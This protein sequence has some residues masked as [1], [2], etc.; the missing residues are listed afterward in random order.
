MR[1]DYEVDEPA[2][3]GSPSSM[4]ETAPAPEP[5]RDAAPPRHGPLTPVEVSTVGI[6]SGLA[7]VLGVLAT[8][9]PFLNAVFQMLAAVPIAMVTVRL[10]A[11][12]AVAS[13]AVTLLVTLVLGG[14][15]SALN[16]GQSALA[17]AVAGVLLRLQVGLGGATLAGLGLGAAL[18]GISVGVL[19]VLVDLRELALQTARVT[20]VGYLDLFGRWSVLTPVTDAL[21]RVVDWG[22][23]W[24]FAVLPA[25]AIL[26]TVL[27]VVLSWW[28]LGIVLARLRLG[29]V[30]DP[31]QTALDQARD[32]RSDLSLAD[33]APGPLPVTL[34]GVRFRYPGAPTGP[35]GDALRGVDLTIRDGEF[36]VVAGPNGSGKSTL[37]WILAGAEP[38]GGQVDRPGPVGLGRHGGTA[39]LAQ[40][41]EL[42]MLGDTVA[43]DIVWGLP[44]ADAADVDV[45]DLL[46]LVG[47]PG[48]GAARTSHLSG[49]QLQRLALAGA[50]ARRPRLLLSDESTAMVDPAGRR[51]L[52]A[53]LS[54]LPA[55]GTTVVHITH[56]LDEAR[57]AHRLVRMEDGRVVSDG[58]VPVPSPPGAAGSASPRPPSSPTTTRAAGAAPWSPPPSL[59]EEHLWADRVSHAYDVG[60]PWQNQ[61]LDNVSLIVSP[62]EGVLVTGD[63]GS[64]KST[65]S[66]ILTGLMRPTWG[67]CTL[68]GAAVTQ[69]V[70]R[71]ALSMQFARL[72]LLRPSVRSDI[73]AAAQAGEDWSAPA[74]RAEEDRL[75]RAAMDEVGLPADLEHRGIDQLSGGQMRRV[76]LAGLLASDPAVIVLDEPLA[77][78]DAESR[79]LLID[80]LGRRR[81]LGLS[82]LVISHD[83][84]GLDA[85]CDRSLSLAA[86][87]LS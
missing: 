74:S 86:G 36:T 4:P 58:P 8:I 82:V 24:W 46:D 16:V 3:H 77:G 29:S 22:I 61:V 13:V 5:E 56:D 60:T 63:N 49:G 72:Q 15:S 23:R 84:E 85:L 17:G 21:T 27:T 41:S 32:A 38:T 26:A 43:E 40:R 12:G 47:L 76:A 25:T 45:E 50:L 7:V 48:L 14:V 39:L 67:Q 33:A 54:G 55:R 35:D 57:S 1:S 80:A 64:G 68:G 78:L 75:V 52:I 51:D 2:D 6:L 69:R 70:G 20:T 37:A 79:G 31:L 28:I 65:L 18:G 19:W 66:R 87:V 62:G 11:R 73:L 30:W 42:Q 59:A 34:T 44:P 53:V 83:T 81:R 71:V 9:M 10:R